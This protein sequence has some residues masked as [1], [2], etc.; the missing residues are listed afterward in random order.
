VNPDCEARVA[1]AID[2]ER[3]R[4]AG[5]LDR[6]AAELGDALAGR[7][8]ENPAE[9]A[10]WRHERDVCRAM[11]GRIRQRAAGDAE[12]AREGEP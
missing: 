11:A 7:H 12:V 9:A 6:R 3:E 10:L 4:C 1:A 2:C 8:Y 5:V